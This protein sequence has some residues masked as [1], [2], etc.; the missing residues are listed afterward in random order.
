[1]KTKLIIG[2]LTVGIVIFGFFN[3][4]RSDISIKNNNVNQPTIQPEII[5]NYLKTDTIER[6]LNYTVRDRNSAA[7]LTHKTTKEQIKGAEK[8]SDLITDYPSKWINNYQSVVVFVEF[9]GEKTMAIGENE[10]LSLEQINLLTSVKIGSFLSI[11]VKYQDTNSAT[12]EKENLEMK[13]YIAIT[14]EGEAEFEGGYQKLIAYLKEN[15]NKK[16][17]RVKF[18]F[19]ETAI[20]NFTID[21]NG[22][23]ENVAVEVSSDD[24]EVDALL[25]ELIKN[26]PKWNPAKNSKGENVSQDFEFVIGNDGC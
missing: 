8:L 22:N 21:K 23:S 11:I 1:M 13:L 6:I 26:M 10:N 14:P 24:S 7:I 17:Q 2:I 3:K 16:I 15:R 25:I 9:D 18:D 5:K 4:D 19:M 12:K 20:I